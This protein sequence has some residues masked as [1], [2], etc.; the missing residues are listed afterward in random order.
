MMCKFLNPWRA[1]RFA[2][3]AIVLSSHNQRVID[4]P[5]SGR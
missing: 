2:L 1:L 3:A 4:V 5:V